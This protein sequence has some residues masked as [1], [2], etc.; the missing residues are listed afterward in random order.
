MSKTKYNVG[1]I[2]RYN[3]VNLVSTYSRRGYIIITRK[4]RML[5]LG[6]SDGYAYSFVVLGDG[7]EDSCFSIHFDYYCKKVSSSKIA[8]ELFC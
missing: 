5:Y 8:K 4:E 7:A 2:L 6:S 1:D 3:D